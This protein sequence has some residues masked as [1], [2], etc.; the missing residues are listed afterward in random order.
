METPGQ[1]ASR[2]LVALDELVAQEGMYLRAG[3][4]DL[5]VETRERAE[6][7]VQEL[8]AMADLAGVSDYQPRVRALLECSDRHAAFIQEKLT[9]LGTEIR[10]TDQALHLAHHMVPAYARSDTAVVPRLLATG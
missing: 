8:V 7:L 1:K 4:F 2:L 5:A 6:P 9:E 3:Y 10:R